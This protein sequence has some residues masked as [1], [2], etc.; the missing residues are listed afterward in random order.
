MAEER[1]PQPQATPARD[2]FISY[3]SQDKA[4]AESACDALES[5]GLVCWI[6]PRD[7]VPGESFAG[8]IVHAI[9][10]TKVIV[11]VL[12]EHSAS[13]QH[14]LREVERASSKRHPVI[15]FRIDLA[16]MPADFEYFLNT[17]QW[18][19]ASAIGVKHA[20]PKLVD[21][22]KSALTQPSTGAHVNAGASAP[23]KT[24]PRRSRAL[25]ALAVIAALLV[26]AGGV[27]WR[28]ARAPGVPSTT[29]IAAAAQ[30][31]TALEPSVAA[32]PA[33]KSVA[34][35]PLKNESGDP[36]QEYFSDGLS[37]SLINSLSHI[38]E[39]KVIGRTSAFHFKNSPETSATIGRQLAV[40]NLIEGS[41]QREGSTIRISVELI[42]AADG[43][44][45]WSE[46][47]D[48]PYRNLFALQDEI[49]L[50]LAKALRAH[51]LPSAQA[52]GA[53]YR[54]PSGNLDA[55]ALLLKGRYYNALGVGLN[56][57]SAAEVLR[58]AVQLDPNYAAAWVEL[59]VSYYSLSSFAYI[60]P[61]RNRALALDAMAHAASLAPNDVSVRYDSAVFKIQY[62]HDPKGA[63]VDIA[64][65][66]RSDPSVP[67]PE[68]LAIVTGCLSGSC[69][70]RYIR[71]IS[72]A[73]A[74]DPLDAI[75][76]DERGLPR[77]FAGELAAAERDW[78][79]IL[80]I[81][82]DYGAARYYIAQILIAENKP[83]EALAIAS[84]E[85]LA[86]NRK[87]ARAFAFVALGRRADAEAELRDMMAHDA[88]DGPREI[89]E[90]YATLGEKQKALDWLQRD[91]DGLHAGVFFLR[92]NPLLRNLA[93][94]PRFR[95]LMDKIWPGS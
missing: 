39:F 16:P 30:P 15:A 46:R 42:N 72:A 67:M 26:M 63:A 50:S 37:E 74:R 51:L 68:E 78:R 10:A 61:D 76:L 9:D 19:D 28:F 47:Y 40:A 2:V 87:A 75:S 24:S 6:A 73:I 88:N 53:M 18:L 54:P 80:E 65:A 62:G 82:P 59:A 92:W 79:R 11:L 35:L 21:A 41:V 83:T 55:Y 8:A 66:E 7:V 12:S 43:R 94:E 85:T 48:R 4:V 70:Q 60:E 14:V 27:L 44:T 23:A 90:V 58:R 52:Q 81:N 84:D 69:Y 34:V 45:L 89:A 38:P 20:F 57:K 36:K 22:V 1:S 13:S 25:V 71:N 5:A 3:A 93:A 64:A 31:S 95:A 49:A 77:Y 91:Y 33:D 29:R 86:V 56:L 17:S 32:A